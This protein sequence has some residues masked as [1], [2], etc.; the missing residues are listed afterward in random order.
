MTVASVLLTGAQWVARLA[1]IAATIAKVVPGAS[2]IEGAI[3]LAG[4][5]AAGLAADEPTIAAAWTDIQTAAAGGQPVSPEQWAQWQVDIDT[6]HQAVVAA[7]QADGA[8][9]G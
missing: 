4:Q 1:P 9:E 2:E 5:V 7:A 8:K 6:A 3:T